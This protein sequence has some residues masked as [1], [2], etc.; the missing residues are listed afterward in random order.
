[1]KQPV[2][3]EEAMARTLDKFLSQITPTLD[4]LD[5]LFGCWPWTGRINKVVVSLTGE[6]R[7]GYGVISIDNHEWLA[8][9]YS[10]GLFI[11]G[12]GNRLTLD[13]VCRN[14][15]CVRP[16]H[17][18][19]MTSRRNSELEHH[20]ASD[21]PEDVIQDLFKIKQMREDTMLWAMLQ[22]LP[23]SRA[24]PGGG[25]FAYGLDGQPFEHMTGPANN[26]SIKELFRR[27]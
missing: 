14:S 5:G 10:Y 27:R 16:D 13:H 25:P 23:I 17:M 9:R 2:R 18:V 19:P 15:L 12:H 22:G 21:T 26:P 7:P 8:H 4:G 11:G 6:V 1:M 20:R 3:T 24:T